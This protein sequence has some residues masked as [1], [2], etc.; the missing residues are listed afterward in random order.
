M[1]AK[2]NANN[3]NKNNIQTKKK[4]KLEPF[5]A[6]THKLRVRGI[7]NKNHKIV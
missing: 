4:K 3:N 1:R 6:Y 2:H 7:T 5:N